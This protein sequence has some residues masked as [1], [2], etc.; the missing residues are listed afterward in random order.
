MEPEMKFHIQQELSLIIWTK[1]EYKS[2]CF[3]DHLV[4]VR[5][6]FLSRFVLILFIDAFGAFVLVFFMLILF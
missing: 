1:K 3:L 6:L 2:C 4:L 5:A